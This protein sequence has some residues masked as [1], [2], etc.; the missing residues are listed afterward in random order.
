MSTGQGAV[1][2]VVSWEDNLSLADYGLNGMT[3]ST[4]PM[5]VYGGMTPFTFKVATLNEQTS[6][7]LSL[8]VIYY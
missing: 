2:V 4:W 5:T 1:A 8:V 3:E 7:S 6:P